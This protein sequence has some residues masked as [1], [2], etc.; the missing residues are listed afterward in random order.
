MLLICYD[1]DKE[2]AHFVAVLHL[3]PVGF[4]ADKSAR[5][6]LLGV[7]MTAIIEMICPHRQSSL[8]QVIGRAKDGS[9]PSE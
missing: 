9:I 4:S 8:S 7:K 1:D 5:P 2:E 6:G 3:F